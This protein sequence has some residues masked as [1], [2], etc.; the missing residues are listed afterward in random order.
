MRSGSVVGKWTATVAL[1]V[2]MSMLSV[3]G[4]EDSSPNT[5]GKDGSIT[6]DGPGSITDGIRPTDAAGAEGLRLAIQRIVGPETSAAF[7]RSVAVSGDRAVV[8]AHDAVY[9]YR[10]VEELW[11]QETLLS[12]P[13]SR[14]KGFGRAVA[15]E[16]SVILVGAP[17]ESVL[18]FDAGKVYVYHLIDGDQVHTLLITP[19]ASSRRGPSERR[20]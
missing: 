12:A 8:G 15:I 14:A 11:V 13:S 5:P 17:N 9:V 16:D 10:L 20:T 7:G 4:C 6:G 3:L 18:F 2:A 1:C 19:Y